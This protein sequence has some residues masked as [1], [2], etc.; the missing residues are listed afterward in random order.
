MDDIL[1]I[2]NDLGGAKT[3]LHSQFTLKGLGKLKYFLRIE[4]AYK[5]KDISLSQMKDAL[6]LLNEIRDDRLPTCRRT[7]NFKLKYVVLACSWLCECYKLQTESSRKL[8]FRYYTVLKEPK[9]EV[10]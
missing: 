5:R 7:T 9:C 6:D 1:L 2:G 8:F 4:I 10:E 3:Y